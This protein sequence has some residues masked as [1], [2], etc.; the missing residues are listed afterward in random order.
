MSR[1]RFVRVLPAVVR[2]R[3]PIPHQ[4]SRARGEG[5]SSRIHDRR[6]ATAT[7]RTSHRCG[8][9]VGVRTE[10]CSCARD[11][12]GRKNVR[13][14]TLD[15]LEDAGNDVRNIGPRE[16]PVTRGARG[17]RSYKP[18]PRLDPSAR[19][20]SPPSLAPYPA[21]SRRS[22]LPAPLIATCG[23]DIPP[24]PVYV[25]MVVPSSE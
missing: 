21:L 8:A 11:G 4:Q 23:V 17:R 1:S 25:A 19:P 7:R 15:G 6:I 12:T 18:S 22:R 20:C 24:V 16:D 14:G 3:E 5:G 2:S 9:A 13:V 10:A